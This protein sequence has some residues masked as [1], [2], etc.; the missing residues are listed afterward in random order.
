MLD[1]IRNLWN[2]IP[3]GAETPI[4]FIIAGIIINA[5]RERHYH[6]LREKMWLEIRNFQAI[7]RNANIP[8]TTF[9]S[10]EEYNYAQG[11]TLL[12]IISHKYS[13]IT[14][15]EELKYDRNLAKK[16]GAILNEKGYSSE[17]AGKVLK[18]HYQHMKRIYLDAVTVDKMVKTYEK[19]FSIYN[20]LIIKKKKE[21]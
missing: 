2:M 14:T 12:K 20:S 3:D 19:D 13:A 16:Y 1:L 6:V 21:Q 9:F 7:M 17:W 10:Q 15:D 4:L 11:E 8:P 18:K 5:L